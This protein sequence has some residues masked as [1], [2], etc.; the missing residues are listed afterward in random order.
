MTRRRRIGYVRV[1]TGEQ[2]GQA[3]AEALQSTALSRGA[4]LEL[5]HETAS[6]RRSRPQ[7]DW[8]DRCAASG[9]VAELWVAALDRLGRSTVDVVMRLDRLSRA[10]CTVISL[11]EGIDLGSA[12][13]RLQVQLLAAFAEFEAEQ[14]AARTREGL[15]AARARGRRLGRPPRRVNLERAAELRAEG[16]SWAEIERQLRVPATTIRRGL[17][18]TPPSGEGPPGPV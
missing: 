2:T 9:Q 4:V 5:V 18:K 12:A 1:S 6:G 16:A 8:I 14:I 3:Q 11:R 10:G 17:A 15:A 7:L 13:G